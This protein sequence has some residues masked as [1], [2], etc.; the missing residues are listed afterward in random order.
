MNEFLNEC[1][2]LAQEP[3]KVCLKGRVGQ[4]FAQ[5]A[6]VAYSLRCLMRISGQANSRI[7]VGD[8]IFKGTSYG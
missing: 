5:P 1:K 6:N 3:G 2:F 7:V 8:G 4:G